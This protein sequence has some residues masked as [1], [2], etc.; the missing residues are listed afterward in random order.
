MLALKSIVLI[1]VGFFLLIKGADFFV[2]GASGI[3]EKFKIPQMIIGLTIVAFGTSAP[4]AAISISAALQGTTGIAIGNVLGSNMLNVL[5]ILGITSC[6]VPLHI[7]KSSLKFD[8]PFNIV[9][10]AVL[11]SMG[12]FLGK[13][14]LLCG[15]ILWAL[16]IF[17]MVKLLKD[18]KKGMAAAAEEEPAQTKNVFL[19]ILF[20][21]GGLAA[22]VWGSDITVENAK[23]IAALLGMS[24]RLIGLT[25]VAFGTSLPELITSA[26]AAK[27]GNADIAVGNILGS[28]IFNI[29]FVLGTVALIAPVEFASA[30]LVDA[31]L[32]IVSMA[33]LMLFF[34]KDKF[35][36]RLQE[37]VLKAA[38][39]VVAGLMIYNIFAPTPSAGSDYYLVGNFDYAGD[40]R[41]LG[42][43]VTGQIAYV[44]GNPFTYALLLLRSMA[45]M[46]TGYL[47]GGTR[48][49]QYGY[50]GAAPMLVTYLVLALAAWTVMWATKGEKRKSIGVAYVILTLLMI[51]GTSAIVWTSM[52]ASYTTVGADEIRGVQGRYF[53]PMFLPF[54]MCFLNGK[55]ESRLVQQHRSRIVFGVMALVN[56]AMIYAL[57]ITKMNI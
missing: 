27:K 11:F 49:F 23:V 48:F 30:F 25:V 15:V 3:A 7:Q 42:T 46:T 28:N 50:L 52:Y 17:F 20:T 56:F 9:I 38:V 47:L 57:V 37:F 51:L 19:L 36:N 18:A 45:E 1:I 10:T 22:V 14:N 54:A 24:D 33:L 8:M 4:E 41:N 55:L 5:L 39:L 31:V 13:L 35:H 29:L 40:K 12:F 34:G 53:I 43:S 2:S 26:T 21:I 32:C 44:L 16:M 6:I